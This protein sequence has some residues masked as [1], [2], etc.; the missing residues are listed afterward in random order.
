MDGE[1]DPCYNLSPM[2]PELIKN[3][4]EEL[5]SRIIGGV[6]S[7]VHQPDERNI[8]LRIFLRGREERLLIS[9]HPAF[10]RIHLTEEA[11]INPP[12]P[13]RFCAYLRSRLTDA[14]IVSIRQIDN[15]R[16]CSIDLKKG[17]DETA[18][19]F[20]LVAE[21][22]GKSSNIIL[23]NKDKD[24]VV[25]DSLR[26]FPAETSVRAVVPG[27]KL[28][29]LPSA[30]VH[31]DGVR[32][33]KGD[34]PGWNE[35]VDNHFSDLV[36]LEQFTLEKNRI[37][38]VIQDATKKA[39][40]KL[41]N[42][43][44]DLAKAEKGLT[45]R[46]TGELLTANYHLIKRGASEVEAIDYTVIPPQV[47][48]VEIDKTLSPK[49]NCERYFKRARKG[50]KAIEVLSQRIP[51]TEEEM[52][53]ISGLAYGLEC[54]TTWQ[55]LEDLKGE[56]IEGRYMKKTSLEAGRVKEAAVVEKAEPVR[57]YVSSEGF[58]VLCGKSGTGND[59]IVRKYAAKEDIW[60][61]IKGIAGS[62]ILIKVAG[63]AG[64]LTKKTI[65]EAASLAAFHSKGR[66]A[67]KVE[68]I[69][70]EARYVK[71]P[72]GAKPGLVTVS[73][74]KSIYVKPADMPICK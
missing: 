47:V 39:A 41:D 21:L 58:E 22:T 10:P 17:F 63:R 11:F 16:I 43:K 25:L 3:I 67:G 71:K 15:E 31:E 5:Q 45:D 59:L 26:Y 36:R 65:E 55:E 8:I 19:S 40:R 68:V 13:L 20:T 74:F 66:E 18:E 9:C 32:I 4:I 70:A 54:V 29:P 34:H 57:R 2:A 14:R 35:A 69:Y 46:L 23:L 62:H 24:G 27:I 42:L 49:E 33:T 51:E 12:A 50:K 28:A 30:P 64:E 6:I 7:R 53:Y 44:G 37:K 61:H 73:E 52:E 72:K 1:K 48:K 56:L 60:F 38:R